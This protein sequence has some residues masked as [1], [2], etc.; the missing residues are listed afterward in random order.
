MEEVM[1]GLLD[2]KIAREA[3]D[4]IRPVI[5][6]MMEREKVERKTLA[7]V[8]LSPHAR[9]GTFINVEDAILHEEI[10]GQPRQ[11]WETGRTYDAYAR[12]KAA[13]TWRTGMTSREVIESHP[14]L[15]IQGDAKYAGSAIYRGII[16]AASGVEDHY[17]EMFAGMYAVTCHGL[18]MT[19]MKAIKADPAIAFI[20]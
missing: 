9:Y 7:L 13:I 1:T 3:A 14:H 10:I 17:D 5:L 4:L 15:L 19:K 18:V 12:G 6:G 20:G 8:V 16:T 11:T 2:Q